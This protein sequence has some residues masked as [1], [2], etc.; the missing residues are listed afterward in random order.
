MILLG[1]S[2]RSIA[3]L[4][5]RAP[6]TIMRELDRNGWK[7]PVADKPVMGRPRQHPAYEA[8]RAGNCARRNRHK[9]RRARKLRPGEPGNALWTQVR[10]KLGERWLPQQIAEHLSQV[11]PTE[12]TLQASHET[13]YTAIYAMPKGEFKKEVISL[14]HQR[15]K[16][17]EPHGRAE[18]RGDYRD[19][20]G[21]H[22]RPPEVEDRLVPGH[23]EGDLIKGKNNKSAVGTLVCRKTR[24]AMLVKLY[25]AMAKDVFE[26]FEMAF[27]PLDEAMRKTLT[28]D[29][30][31]EMAW[32]EK[33]AQSTGLKIYFCDPHSPWQRGSNENTNGL[34]RDFL[35]KGTDLSVHSQADLDL[36]AWRLNNRPWQTLGWKTP[37]QAFAE[38]HIQYNATT[39]P[40]VA[41]GP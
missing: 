36:I 8:S 32:H 9:A 20:L 7:R 34:L 16:N 35:P 33:L 39:Q 1:N 28:Y 15:R 14:L 26:G 4:L 24:F 11:H 21:I 5:A 6:S 18:R 12:P 38:E 3:R 41:L 23:W 22:M 10:A 2:I 40:G 30:G 19:V 13:I 27:S 17:R 29:R 37:M 25:G 31:K